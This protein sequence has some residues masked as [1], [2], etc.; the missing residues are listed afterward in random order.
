MDTH[1]TK[2]RIPIGKRVQSR[3]PMFPNTSRREANKAEVDGFHKRV[4][5]I[6]S[7]MSL[8]DAYHQYRLGN[9]FRESRKIDKDIVMYIV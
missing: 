6:P 8:E 1:A 4:K 7:D 2:E 5:K 9:F 3:K